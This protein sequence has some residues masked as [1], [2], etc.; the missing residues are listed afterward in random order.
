MVSLN[1]PINPHI[2]GGRAANDVV[3]RAIAW[4]KSKLDKSDLALRA[5]AR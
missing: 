1:S 4:F 3:F 5:V 2:N